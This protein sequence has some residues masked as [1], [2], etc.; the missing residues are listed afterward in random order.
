ME[1]PK[2]RTYGPTSE[3]P[4]AFQRDTNK[5][6]RYPKPADSR[7]SDDSA[8]STGESERQFKMLPMEVPCEVLLYFQSMLKAL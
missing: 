5:K 6:K 7:L 3:Q 2:K 1:A 8:V 4:A